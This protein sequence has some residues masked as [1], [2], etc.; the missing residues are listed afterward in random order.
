MGLFNKKDNGINWQKEVFDISKA[1]PDMSRQLGNIDSKFN[2]HVDAGREQRKEDKIWQAKLLQ[3]SLEC[4]KG[5]QIDNMQVEVDTL[6]KDKIKREGKF[7]GVKLVYAV[8][9][10]VLG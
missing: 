3:N 5:K 1:L 8:I 4:V 7:L 2:D 6:N 9:L 10:G